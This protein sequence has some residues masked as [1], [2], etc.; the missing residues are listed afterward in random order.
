MAALVLDGRSLARALEIPLA[1]RVAAATAGNG[2]RPPRLALVLVGADRSSALHARMKESACRRTGIEPLAVHLPRQTETA[3]VL[4]EIERLNADLAVDGIFV[5]YPLPPHVDQRR[6]FDRIALAKDVG[7]DS[8]LG[9]GR[10]VLGEA[11]FGSATPA[12]ILLLLSHY[13][14]P[15]A[16]RRAVVVGAGTLLARP[17][18]TMLLAADATVTICDPATA[19]DL[20]S[21]VQQAEVLVAAAGSPHLV[22][23]AWIRDGAVVIDTGFHP[24]ATAAPGIATQRADGVDLGLGV[25]DVEIAPAAARCSAYTPVPGGVGPMTIAALLAHTVEAAE[26]SA[27]SLAP[28]APPAPPRPARRP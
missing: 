9:F 6:C 15:L 27:G 5:Q 10:Q 1:Q 4:A 18:A 22:K 23:G 28:L 2:G 26:R 16:G 24:T 8:C 19:A 3:G 12:A 21:L 13:G 11:A 20:P 17:L 14:I 7:G 25:G